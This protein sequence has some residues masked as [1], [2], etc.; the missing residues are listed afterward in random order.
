MSLAAQF[1][2]PSHNYP[3]PN[4]AGFLTRCA[5]GAEP[6]NRPDGVAVFLVLQ[7]TERHR[8]RRANGINAGE[9]GQQP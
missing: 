9:N 4:S 3:G 8:L 1:F 2:L 7:A 5:A 6:C